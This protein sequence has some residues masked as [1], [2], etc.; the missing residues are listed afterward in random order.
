MKIIRMT[1]MQMLM[2]RWNEASCSWPTCLPLILPANHVRALAASVDRCTACAHSVQN[3]TG[4]QTRD[5]ADP[6]DGH[7]QLAGAG[8]RVARPPG[9]AARRLLLPPPGR[10]VEGQRPAHAAGAPLTGYRCFAYTCA[11]LRGVAAMRRHA[12]PSLLWSSGSSHPD[13]HW[14]RKQPA[15]RLASGHAG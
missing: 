9:V 10:P 12:S 15:A 7:E 8:R 14:Q 1:V 2:C 5:A 11:T 6:A 4:L 3:L 13:R